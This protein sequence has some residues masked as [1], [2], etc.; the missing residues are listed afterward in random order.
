MNFNHINIGDKA[1]VNGEQVE[2]MGKRSDVQLVQVY[3][4]NPKSERYL[5]V[6]VVKPEQIGGG[7]GV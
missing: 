3:V 2:V 5:E 4:E 7:L 1:I 6:M